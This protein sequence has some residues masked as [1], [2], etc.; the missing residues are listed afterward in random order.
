MAERIDILLDADYD[1]LIE[2]KD[3]VIGESNQQHADLLFQTIPGELKEYPLTGFGAVR[4]IKK[5]NYS[6]QQFVRDYKVELE[7]DGYDDPEISFTEDGKLEI[8]I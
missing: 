4:K 5:V 6:P 7:N 1:L 3:L 2:N 8:N